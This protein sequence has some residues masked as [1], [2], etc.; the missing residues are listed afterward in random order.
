MHLWI[1]STGTLKLLAALGY[2]PRTFT[3]LSLPSD[4]TEFIARRV[5]Y[6]N[7]TWID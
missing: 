7:H 1:I 6:D 4:M 2:P 3:S 5:P